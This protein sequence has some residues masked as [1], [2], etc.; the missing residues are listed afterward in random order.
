MDENKDHSE[1][2]IR[3]LRNANVKFSIARNGEYFSTISVWSGDSRA[4]KERKINLT[5]AQGKFLYYLPF[6]DAEP[7]SIE[8]IMKKGEIDPMHTSE[9]TDIVHELDTLKVLEKI[10]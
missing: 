7:Q 5:I 9:I 1:F 2:K 10:Y 4:S 3:E 8:Q 6:P